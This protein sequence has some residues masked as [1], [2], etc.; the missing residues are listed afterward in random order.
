MR[1]LG[2]VLAAVAS[3]LAA[4]SAAAAGDWRL[5]QAD[6]VP[7]EY[8]QGLT[9]MPGESVLFVGVLEG[10]YRTDTRL[11]E[12]ARVTSVY[13]AD[14]SALGFN[15]VGDP[16]YDPSEG[17]RLIAP[18]ECYRPGQNPANTCGM[19]G[20][21]VIDPVTLAW[22]YWVRLDPADIPK[23]TWAEVSP[24]GRLIWTSSG[25]DLL[26]Y[27]TADVTAANAATS[28]SSVAIH[29]VR[30]L[31]GAVP[32]SGVTGGVFRGG[33]LF[34]AGAVGGLLEVR[35]V[36]LTGATP[37]RT[38]LTLP[39]VSAEP[40]GLDV[41]D[42][43]GGLLHW[44]LS[45]VVPKPTYGPG[46]SELLT[47]LPASAA[48]LRVVAGRRGHGAVVRVTSRFVGRSHAVVGAVV[49]LGRQRAHT[50]ARG[51]ASFGRAPRERARVTAT[52]LELRPGHATLRR[53]R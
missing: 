47:F 53:A 33:R 16:T 6:P 29:P 52:K 19:G 15:H 17:G 32:P 35:S 36:D 27:S 11:R 48:L 14:V 5:A 42:M 43:R 31:P 34:L 44:L 22:R 21:G 41:L 45:P 10:A 18:M 2:L 51:R 25:Q 3:L 24:D 8:F 40:E 28:A 9:H 23:A 38:E 46:H 30:R 37:E 12:M 20:F 13:P 50:D 39:G 4:Q 26:A 1:R 49:R 7:I